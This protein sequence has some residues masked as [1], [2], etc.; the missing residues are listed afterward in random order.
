MQGCSN[1]LSSV[2]SQ[3]GQQHCLYPGP[4]PFL[5]PSFPRSL[6]GPATLVMRAE[7]TIR[8]CHTLTA[9]AAPLP[10]LGYRLKH[11]LI[12]TDLPLQPLSTHTHMHSPTFF[13]WLHSANK[14]CCVARVP[15]PLHFQ[16]G[17]QLCF[18]PFVWL[19]NTGSSYSILHA[20]LSSSGCEVER[21]TR[22]KNED[23]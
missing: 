18:S 11:L 22:E 14:W 9:G 19:E 16:K 3:C 15:P 12:N 20:P 8:A 21:A 2:L 1:S 6:L 23:I 5:P 4:F 17:P 10:R 7:Y 13:Y